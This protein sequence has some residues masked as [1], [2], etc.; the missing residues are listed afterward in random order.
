MAFSR[1]RE[2]P[3]YPIV[4]YSSER[5]DEITTISEDQNISTS[6]QE[7]AGDNAVPLNENKTYTSTNNKKTSAVKATEVKEAL[8]Q[9]CDYIMEIEKNK[10]I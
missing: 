3:P 9:I 6:M 8:D 7:N 10:K 4:D 2:R 1:K 5:N